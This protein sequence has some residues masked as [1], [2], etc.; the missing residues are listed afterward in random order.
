MICYLEDVNSVEIEIINEYWLIEEGTKDKFLNTTKEI[1][2]KYKGH[3]ILPV[4][5]IVKKS[6]FL[7]K[8]SNFRCLECG[9]AIPVSTRTDYKSRVRMDGPFTCSYCVENKMIEKLMDSKSLVEKYNQETL[10]PK[11]YICSLTLLEMIALLSLME[12][13]SMNHSNSSK[14][15]KSISISGVESLDHKLFSSLV[16]KGALIDATSTPMEILSAKRLIAETVSKMDLSRPPSLIEDD[17]KTRANRPCFYFCQPIVNERVVDKNIPD[18]IL[19]AIRSKEISCKDIED[20]THIINEIQTQKLHKAIDQIRKDYRLHIEESGFL[21]SVL[22]Y[23][24]KNHSPVGT[25]FS[26]QSIARKSGSLIQAQKVSR[27]GERYIFT[28]LLGDYCRKIEKNNWS[29]D[30][31]SPLPFSSQTQPLE[32][33]FARLYCFQINFDTMSTRQVIKSWLDCAGQPP[34]SNNTPL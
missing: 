15:S 16:E 34:A 32:S 22:D 30:W 8:F 19:K 4:H 6:L 7:P 24:S 2:S 3:R 33:M 25:H 27:D 12:E 20:I 26:M 13:P 17:F 14:E 11:E 10:K 31:E 23:F 9:S 18:E 29:L 1:Y 21:S 5:K 28:K